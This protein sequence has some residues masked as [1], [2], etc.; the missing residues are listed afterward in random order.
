MESRYKRIDLLLK[1]IDN[2]SKS[3]RY[4]AMKSLVRYILIIMIGTVISPIMS[5][6][7]N[8]AETQVEMADAL[9]SNGKIYVVVLVIV[10]VFT[11]LGIF[12]WRTDRKLKRLEEEVKNLNKTL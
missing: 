1:L 9:R 2:S 11:G 5:M 12:A 4:A 10:I 8:T 6:A 3:I 7:Q